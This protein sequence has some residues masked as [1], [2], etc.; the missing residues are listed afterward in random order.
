[1]ILKATKV[2]GMVNFSEKR[3]RKRI[4]IRMSSQAHSIP[5]I[6]YLFIFQSITPMALRHVHKKCER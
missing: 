4:R 3:K 1:V 5:L 6:Y 2:K